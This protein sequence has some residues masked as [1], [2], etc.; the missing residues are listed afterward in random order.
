MAISG[1]EPLNKLLRNLRAK[2]FDL[3]APHLKKREFHLGYEIESPNVST[4]EVV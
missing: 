1:P 2:D 3:L 4:A